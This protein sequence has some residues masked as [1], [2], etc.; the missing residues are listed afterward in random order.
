ML[1]YNAVSF[2]SS[3]GNL[4]KKCSRR[5]RA[6]AVIVSATASV[7]ATHFAG[8]QT[9]DSWTSSSG[10]TWT[11]LTDWSQHALPGYADFNLGSTGGYTVNIPAAESVSNL[12]VDTDNVTLTEPGF[13]DR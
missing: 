1:R 12:A 4:Q 2:S 8:A 11:T 6:F 3:N 7:A 10:G 9:I 5:C 13:E